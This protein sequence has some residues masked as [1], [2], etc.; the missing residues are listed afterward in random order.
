MAFKNL[1]DSQVKEVSLYVF[2]ENGKFVGIH[3]YR[4]DTFIAQ[5]YR[6]PLQ[7][8]A[9]KYTFVVWSGLNDTYKPFSLTP[10]VST[11][12]DLQVTVNSAVVEKKLD[13]LFHGILKNVEITGQYEKEVIVPLVKDTNTIRV[14][15]QDAT[16]ASGIDVNNYTFELIAK[17]SKFDHQNNV[18]SGDEITFR[19]YRTENQAGVGAVAEL[20][21]F[22]LMAQGIEY[23]LKITEKSTGKVLLNA[24]LVEYLTS[25]AIDLKGMTKQEYLDREDTFTVTYVFN[26]QTPDE[27]TFASV[28]IK[29]NEWYIRKQDLPALGG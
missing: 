29:M 12:N 26:G 20:N 16:G 6:M 4:A 13:S 10:G 21:T 22:R 11:L 24:D 25:P 1:V 8:P 17:N 9:G 14:I 28:S 5:D 7:L 23:R 27:K 15:L 3:S 2:D 19:P 18:L